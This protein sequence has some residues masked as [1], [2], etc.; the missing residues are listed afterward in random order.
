VTPA[1]EILEQFVAGK[2]A[3]PLLC[4]DAVIVTDDYAAVIDGAT[5]VTGRR[6]GGLSGG[7]FGGLTGGRWAMSACLD[8][9]EELSAGINAATGVAALTRTLAARLD[10]TLS[11]ADRPSA[12]VTIYSAARRELWQVG[13]VGFSYPGL[14]AG[15][16]QPRKRIDRIAASF[17]AAFL[18]A[19]AATGTID[20][21][22]PGETDPARPA[23]QTLIARQGSLR[24]TTGPYGYAGIDGR[25]V[26]SELIVVHHVPENVSDLAIASDGYPLIAGTLAESESVLAQLLER[27]PWCVNELAGTKGVLK[28]QISYDDRAYLRL[29]I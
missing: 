4:E 2:L 8:A 13:D 24:N 29:K 20:L 7:V 9:I 12:S 16:G 3:D 14:P 19:E 6:Y 22:H 10:S 26:P 5:D 11:P 25:P 27:D 15:A 23:V 18:A 28:G 1:V 17:R 21:T